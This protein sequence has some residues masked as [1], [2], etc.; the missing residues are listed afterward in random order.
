MIIKID[1]L[2][3]ID[4]SEFYM[5]YLENYIFSCH[6][7]PI[8]LSIVGKEFVRK[9]NG[10]EELEEI[11]IKYFTLIL[12]ENDIAFYKEVILEKVETEEKQLRIW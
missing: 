2:E 8:Q 1:F 6:F 9:K 11:E 12:F 5:N 4:N 7:L 3:I 10:K